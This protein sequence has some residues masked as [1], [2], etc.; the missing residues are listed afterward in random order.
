MPDVYSEARDTLTIS[1]MDDTDIL[2]AVQNLSASA[3]TAE[4]RIELTWDALSGTDG[5]K[6]QILLRLSA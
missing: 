2:S 3:G 6:G 1:T 4:G 5:Y